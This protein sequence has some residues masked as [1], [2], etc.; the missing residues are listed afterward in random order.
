MNRTQ[1]SWSLLLLVVSALLSCNERK[2]RA[3]APNFKISIFLEGIEDNSKIYLKKRDGMFYLAI[4]S[5]LVQRQSA[6]FEGTIQN[7][8]IFGIFVDGIATGIFP[9][10]EE[11]TIQINGSIKALESVKITGTPSNDQLSSYKAEI[12]NITNSIND[13]FFD[14]QIARAENNQAQLNLLHQEME[15][16]ID[17]KNKYSIDFIRRHKESIASYLVWYALEQSD[18]VNKDTLAV[19]YKELSSQVRNNAMSKIM[20]EEIKMLDS[21]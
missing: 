18:Q 1:L 21:L 5:T 14:L 16:I 10:I 7:A 19:L 15:K 11:G 12:L 17:K 6:Q 3:V 2:E 4:D 8:E 9:I 13:Q 20:S